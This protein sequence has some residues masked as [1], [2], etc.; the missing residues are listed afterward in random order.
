MQ[1]FVDLVEYFILGV[2]AGMLTGFIISIIIRE[3]W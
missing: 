2:G 3:I 1:I